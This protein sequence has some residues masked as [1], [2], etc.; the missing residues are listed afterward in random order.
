MALSFLLALTLNVNPAN[1]CALRFDEELVAAVAPPAPAAPGT[2]E[3][4]DLQRAMAAID[5]AVLAPAPAQ[6]LTAV[7]APSHTR[8]STPP[9]TSRAPRTAN[10]PATIAEATR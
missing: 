4:T 1:A 6:A 9:P 3:A 7:P 10:A 8:P 2:A 5:A